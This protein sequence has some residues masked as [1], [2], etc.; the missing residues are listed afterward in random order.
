MGIIE[1]ILN[2][3]KNLS[4]SKKSEIIKLL[5]PENSNDSENKL[6]TDYSKIASIIGFPPGSSKEEK[7]K[8]IST[9]EILQ[10]PNISTT[11][12]AIIIDEILKL[13]KNLSDSQKKEILSLLEP[14]MEENS[15]NKVIEDYSNIA[16]LL[17]LSPDSSNEQKKKTN[18][19]IRNV[20]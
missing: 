6:I 11:E 13:N 15:K 16:S 5:E 1:E 10:D 7:K 12:K 4:D 20:Q 9:L 2:L 3:T 19:K 18:I 17:G 14:E 8:L